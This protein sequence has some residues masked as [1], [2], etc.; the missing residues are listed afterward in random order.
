MI[1]FSSEQTPN[2]VALNPAEHRELRLL[3]DKIEQHAAAQHLVP[4]MF[5]EYVRLA[6]CYPIV[7]SKNEQTGQFAT[8][9]L[10]GLE[11]NEN[12][13]WQDKQWQAVYV[14]MQVRRQPFFVG[15]EPS[16]DEPGKT[17]YVLCIDENS[18][19]LSFDQGEALFD[20]N[21]E[22]TEVFKQSYQVI[23]D[24][25]KDE[26]ITQDFVQ[27]L[28]ELDLIE[29]MS[30]DIVLDNQQK[31]QINGLYTISN[32]R[33]SMLKATELAMLNDKGY[34]GACFA[35]AHSVAQIYALIQKK[36][37]SIADNLG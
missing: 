24:I 36:N 31:L 21:G 4:A 2:L 25:L 19:A 30:L 5:S 35:I 26:P 11:K 9:V 23:S 3:Q 13:F 1:E 34:L 17:K 32:E 10:L 22:Q 27:S 20:E 33:L 29:P 15:Q 18:P 7:I 8:S 6:V 37:Q 14:P 28:V 12:L 16:V